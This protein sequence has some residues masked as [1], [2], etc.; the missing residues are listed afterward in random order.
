[1]AS[2]NPKCKVKYACCI[3][4]VLSASYH[5]IILFAFDAEIVRKLQSQII[6]HRIWL[7]LQEHTYHY[8]MKSGIQGFYGIWST[9]AKVWENVS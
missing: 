9:S 2:I 8:I 6:Q 5:V 4:G 7:H 1:M 3:K